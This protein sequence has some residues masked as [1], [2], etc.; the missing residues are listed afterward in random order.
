MAGLL[1]PQVCARATGG[2]ATAGRTCSRARTRASSARLQRGA[3][4]PPQFMAAP[5]TTPTAVAEA[6]GG[7]TLKKTSLASATSRLRTPE[8]AAGARARARA[9]P[10]VAVAG[11]R[12]RIGAGA[13]RPLRM[14][15]GTGA[16]PM[17]CVSCA[18]RGLLAD[19]AGS[20]GCSSETRMGMDAV[21]SI[22]HGDGARR[23]CTVVPLIIGTYCGG[24]AVCASPWACENVIASHRVWGWQAG[25]YIEGIGGPTP[26]VYQFCRGGGARGHWHRLEC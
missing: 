16:E 18:P 6:E 26:V 15:A 24:Y 19:G 22:S 25:I 3:V 2:A 9:R 23:S 12:R 1:P 14:I 20:S 7:G 11:R 8:G 21:D 10:T 4:P 17:G 5:S 13:D